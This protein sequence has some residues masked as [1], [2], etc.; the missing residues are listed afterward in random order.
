VR[1]RQALEDA[2]MREGIAWVDEQEDGEWGV[3]VVA[4]VEFADV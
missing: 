2:V 1:A 4:A 3:W